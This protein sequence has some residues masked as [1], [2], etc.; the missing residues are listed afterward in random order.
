MP[1]PI[2]ISQV[3]KYAPF[4]MNFVSS[5]FGGAS[6]A[7]QQVQADLASRRQLIQTLTPQAMGQPS[8]VSRASDIALRQATNR[9]MQSY[10]ASARQ[11][12]ISGTTPARAQQGRMAAAGTQAMIQQRGQLALGAQ[13]QLGALTQGALQTQMDLENAEYEAKG[14]FYQGLGELF[15]SKQGGTL[16]PEILKKFDELISIARMW[17]MGGGAGNQ[18]GGRNAGGYGGQLGRS[19]NVDIFGGELR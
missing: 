10:G 1:D 16:D 3:A 6:P 15:G 13:Q 12:G 14:V 9:Y 2:T 11:A 7:E 5:L 8:A 18:G 4:A 19:S 17:A